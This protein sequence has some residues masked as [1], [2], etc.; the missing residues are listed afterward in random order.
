MGKESLAAVAANR[1]AHRLSLDDAEGSSSYFIEQAEKATGFA[2]Q[3]LPMSLRFAFAAVRA[4]T[5]AM[6]HTDDLDRAHGLCV[7]AVL[8]GHALARAAAPKAKKTGV[9]FAKANVASRF[10]EE[11]GHSGPALLDGPLGED[12]RKLVEH[13]AKKAPEGF[14]SD[15]RVALAHA[16]AAGVALFAKERGL[17]LGALGG[18]GKPAPK[19]QR[20]AA[21][22][23]HLAP[24]KE[25]LAKIFA[26]LDDDAPRLVLADWLTEQGDPRGE[27]IQL[28]CA[29]GRGTFGVGAKH[30]ERRGVKLPFAESRRHEEAE[31]ALLKKFEKK[32]LEPVRR[33]VQE[34]G[35]RR[36]FLE[37][38][39]CDVEGFVGGLEALSQEPVEKFHLCRF[40]AAQLKK[41]HA[42]APHPTAWLYDLS[43]NHLEAS[44]LELLGS[45]CFAGVRALDLCQNRFGDAGAIT[46]APLLPRTLRRLS[47]ASNELSDAA[48]TALAKSEAWPKLTHLS[49]GYNANLGDAS[50]DALAGAK[51]LR[52]LQ[53]SGTG[54]TDA[55]AAR[56]ATLALPGLQEL[57][58]RSRVLTGSGAKA[59]VESK[60]L[61][62]LK[63]LDLSDGL[64]A[65]VRAAALARFGPRPEMQ[66]AIFFH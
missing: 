47:M 16:L 1:K 13:W 27:F 11:W 12:A 33:Y 45:R 7:L 59:L 37:K 64:D 46:A 20:S 57:S 6:V 31:K 50:L 18:I 35:F 22:A 62:G 23:K 65:K 41:L 26:R 58:I 17:D 4:S 48:V 38:V 25:L 54:V 24:P 28:Q 44:D 63:F 5:D 21:G 52:W 51:S 60:A 42:L 29:L 9:A 53:L 14:E 19:E 3:P 30:I 56:L 36:G 8:D 2:R 49:L 32:W 39:V 66:D 40:R 34:W 15:T 61:S 43:D 10:V 55:G